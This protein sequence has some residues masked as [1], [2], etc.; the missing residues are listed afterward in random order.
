MLVQHFVFLQQADG[1]MHACH[2]P[3]IK[4]NSL[5]RWF[6]DQ[7][8]TCLSCAT[9]IY[10]RQSWHP[11]PIPW[12]VR[13]IHG[14]SPLFFSQVDFS[15][16]FALQPDGSWVPWDGQSPACAFSGLHPKGHPV[17]HYLPRSQFD[18]YFGTAKEYAQ[19][20]TSAL[21]GC[22]NGHAAVSPRFA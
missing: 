3:T 8:P 7:P 20:F 10:R 5:W 22:S 12:V 11:K 14:A 9:T 1:L 16:A 17:G 13:P 19:S 6:P 15:Y 21:H 4:I 2:C 18:P